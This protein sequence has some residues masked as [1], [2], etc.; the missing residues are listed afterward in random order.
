MVPFIPK[1]A[2]TRDSAN[3]K[4]VPINEIVNE[5]LIGFSEDSFPASVPLCLRTFWRLTPQKTDSAARI[6]REVIKVE[7]G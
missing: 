2:N 1:Y 7:T 6:T 3:R 4:M 5:G